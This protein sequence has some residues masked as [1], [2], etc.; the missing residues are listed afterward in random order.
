M[1]K[2]KRQVPRHNFGI[3]HAVCAVL[4]VSLM[5]IPLAAQCEEILHIPKTSHAPALD[6]Y[7]NGVPSNA[8]IA[9]TGFRQKEPGD[10]TPA[11]QDTT[12][13]LSYDDQYLYAIYV[14]KDKDP[15]QIHARLS[16]REDIVGDDAVELDIDTFHDH[17]RYFRFLVNP[18]G[19]QL[20]ARHTEGQDDDFNFDTQWES[21]G[22]LTPAGYVVKIAIPFKSLRYPAT[23][24]QH[25]GIAVG[26]IIARNNEF[27]YWPTITEKQSNIAAQLA[28]ADLAAPADGHSNLQL[29]PYVNIGRSRSLN[30]DT[31]P[32]SWTDSNDSRIGLDAKW[33]LSNSFAID[34]T[35]HPDFSQV[36][37]DTPQATVD[38]RYEVLYPE[39]RPFFLENASTFQTPQPLFF[40]RRI[41]NPGY[42]LRA[43]GHTDDW[44][45][46][47]LAIDDKGPG[48]NLA[49]SDVNAGKDAHVFVARAQ[50][51]F[52]GGSNVGLILTDRSL[53]NASD[54]VLGAD[55]HYQ[56]NDQWAVNAQL[57]RSQSRLSDST[58]NQGGL[59]YL[60]LKRTDH[61]SFYSG[62]LIDIDPNFDTTLGFLPRTDI[63]QLNQVL[64]LFKFV[65]DHP[66]VQSYGSVFT[67]ITTVNHAG[68]L[69]DRSLDAA[70]AVS[71]TR[72]TNLELHAINAYEY[73]LTKG[74][75]KNGAQIV[76]TTS[77]FNWLDVNMTLDNQ[78]VINYVAADGAPNFAGAAHALSL[79]VVVRPSPRWRIEEL[80]LYNDLRSRETLASQAAD[81]NVYRDTL[82]R[83]TFAYQHNRFLGA[84]VILDYSVLRTNPVLSGLSAG[85]HL[86]TDIQVNY[87][88]SPGTAIYAGYVDQRQNL[89][90]I[91]QPPILQTT[92]NFSLQ[93]GRKIYVKLA[94]LYQI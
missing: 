45:L 6:E 35:L 1:T 20:D 93:T 4:T 2:T 46:G 80:L 13:Y 64:G 68:V 31:S 18:Y 15:S 58:R 72:N 62:R 73:Y 88:L 56:W 60:E 25:W 43:T 26:R 39:K 76:F 52:A 66:F 22:K 37:S 54:Q 7:I 17:Q 83:T 63:R 74:F 12:A 65:E 21:E 55:L 78:P 48:E 50:R 14:A 67:A 23:D 57:A 33:V 3:R 8:G 44:T 77:W 82:S 19:V 36:E 92:D 70:L 16:K 32:L 90:L 38:K 69:Q 29:N 10:G 49:K 87:I 71:M 41:L 27:S 61:T 53:G 42:G 89:Q 24:I 85:K 30:V 86:N 75:Q 11:S 34:A 5:G 79:D 9:I 40:S 81:T 94:Y 51:D 59:R 47:A 91:G 84:R 28:V